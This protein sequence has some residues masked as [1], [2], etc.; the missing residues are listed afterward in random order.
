MQKITRFKD[1]TATLFMKIQSFTPH[2]KITLLAA[3]LAGIGMLFYKTPLLLPKINPIFAI[4]SDFEQ[5]NRQIREQTIAPDSARVRF[6]EIVKA[7]REVNLTYKDSLCV[8]DSTAFVFPVKGY[9]ARSVGGMGMGYFPRHYNMFDHG[10]QVSHPAQDIFVRDLNGD[11]IDDN[12]GQ[13]VDLLAMR[14]GV[15]IGVETNW[16]P[17]SSYRGGNFIWIYDPCMDGLFY[18]AHSSKVIVQVG[19]K[20]AIGQKIGEVGRTG[21]N[22]A[23]PRS[24]THLHLM[25]LQLTAEGLPEPRNPYEWLKKAK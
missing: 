3:L 20:I 17:E 24:Q 2:M 6:K 4:G 10:L 15:V 23:K 14:P 19:D 25:Y 13:P 18:Y 7:L 21:M 11:N 8:S 9:N 12:T 5:L 1:S 22:A 16:Q